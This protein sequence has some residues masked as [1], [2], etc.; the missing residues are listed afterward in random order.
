MESNSPVQTFINDEYNQAT[1]LNGFESLTG[2]V[3]NEFVFTSKIVEGEQR[4]GLLSV[5]ENRLLLDNLYVN[6]VLQTVNYNNQTTNK[7]VFARLFQVTDKNNRMG[8]YSS[9]EKNWVIPLDLY[10]YINYDVTTFNGIGAEVIQYKKVDET[11]KTERN[12]LKFDENNVITRE[13]VPGFAP[14]EKVIDAVNYFTLR[15]PRLK[16]YK[17]RIVNNVLYGYKNDKNVFKTSLEKEA[18]VT[19]GYVGKYLIVQ[20]RTLLPIDANKYSFYDGF[21]KYL[22]K[23]SLVDLTNG[24]V[25]EVKNFGYVLN[26]IG[27]RVNSK[28][29]DVY[30]ISSANKIVN[31]T[32][33]DVETLL[34]NDKMKLLTNLSNLEYSGF[35]D[36]GTNKFYANRR[37]VNNQFE[38]LLDLTNYDSVNY[39]SNEKLI[40]LGKDGRFG[41]INLDGEIVIPF[42]YAQTFSFMNGYS[43]NIDVDSGDR[44]TVSNEGVVRKFTDDEFY[45][46][47]GLIAEVKDTGLKVK[48][49]TGEE[50]ISLNND[51]ELSGTFSITSNVDGTRRGMI[52]RIR[53]KD[54]NEFT[55]YLIDK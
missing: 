32:L 11:L 51:Y 27:A 20:T 41:V 42:N 40:S 31:Q 46:A 52:V 6:I 1:I 9:L 4:L 21:D 7:N 17:Y 10:D 24:R 44:V 28:N 49:Y 39:L 18:N 36:A 54:T 16:D 47:F 3:N 8:L 48:N 15:D 38:I 13:V 43:Y 53:N 29:E 26:S 34:F 55:H 35:V 23:T 37:V 22:L 19:K 45:L 12:Y 30:F 5:F 14:G 50:L 2:I 33:L 25:R